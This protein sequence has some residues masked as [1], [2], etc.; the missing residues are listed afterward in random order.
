MRNLTK[1]FICAARLML[2]LA[3]TLTFAVGAPAFAET[4]DETFKALGLSKSA[5]PKE[6][7]DALTKRYYDESQGAGKGSFSKY[8]EPIPISKYLNPH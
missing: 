4:P 5:S 2:I 6:L 1:I 8:W 3:S 7:Y